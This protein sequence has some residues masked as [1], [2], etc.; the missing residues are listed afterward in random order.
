VTGDVDFENMAVRGW[1]RRFAWWV[2][3]GAVRRV[4]SV[5]EKWG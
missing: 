2:V 4:E 1:G 3:A 5:A